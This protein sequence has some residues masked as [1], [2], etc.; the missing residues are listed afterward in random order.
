MP[1]AL[2][3]N[4]SNWLIVADAQQQAAFVLHL[5]FGLFVTLSLALLYVP[6][7][8]K[9]LPF[10]SIRANRSAQKRLPAAAPGFPR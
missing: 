1:G 10:A 9:S 7:S 5:R 6:Y 2:S 4:R 8:M 3:I